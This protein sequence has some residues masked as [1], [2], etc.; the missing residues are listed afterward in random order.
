MSRRKLNFQF[1]KV[2][3]VLHV[4]KTDGEVVPVYTR[5]ASVRINGRQYFKWIVQAHVDD[6]S[7]D[8]WTKGPD[9]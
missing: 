2:L 6:L 7:E 1:R 4:R 3:P 5:E 8:P 9:E